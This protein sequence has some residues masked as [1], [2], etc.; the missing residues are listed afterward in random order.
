M[1][2][3]VHAVC[4]LIAAT[5]IYS[6]IMEV[7][8]A[9][10]TFVVL[11]RECLSDKNANGC[12]SVIPY[13]LGNSNMLLYVALASVCNRRLMPTY[14][15]ECLHTIANRNNARLLSELFSLAARVLAGFSCHTPHSR[16][17]CVA[18]HP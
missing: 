2:Q 17:A 18:W 10:N 6:M 13:V 16:Y 5:V 11:N 1:H 4:T 7:I 3:F 15:T 14:C 9:A 8:S 12:R